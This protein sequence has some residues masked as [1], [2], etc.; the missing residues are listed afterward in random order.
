MRGAFFRSQLSGL[1]IGVIALAA[2]GP[3]P[4]GSA[5][6]G[7]GGVSG[8]GGSAGRGG[9]AGTG[10]TSGTGGSAGTGAASS[11]CGASTWPASGSYTINVNGTSR[12]YVV[13][14][15]DPYSPQR[16]Y[17]L[18]FAWH[19]AGGTAQQIA[20]S[21]FYGLL[22]RAAGSAIFVAGQ[23]LD[24]GQG[25]ANWANTGGRDIAFARAL[26]DSLR[27]SYCIDDGRIFSTGMSAGGFMSNLVGCAL[28]DV[29]RAIAPMSGAGPSPW[30]STST[31][32]GQVAAWLSHGNTD[33]IVQFQMGV[34]SRDYWRSANHCTTQGTSDPAT[35]CIAYSGCDA[36][37]PVTWC[38]FTGGHTI[39]SF[40]SEAIWNFFAPL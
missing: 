16:P 9:S 33:T 29:V 28:G 39:P 30:L 38:E 27:K 11:G 34:S 37:H 31:C 12:S 26:V 4:T 2:C 8:T 15:P 25:A 17:R 23:G 14:I 13:T 36:G 10:G 3:N 32:R 18:I 7:R 6:G 19:G 35:G 24:A 21:R 5:T 1:A 20:S 22:P 40:A